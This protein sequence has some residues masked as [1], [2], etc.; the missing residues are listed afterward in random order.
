MV[1]FPAHILLDITTFDC[2]FLYAE[3]V[4]RTGSDIYRIEIGS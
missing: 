4:E 2:C 3:A 1:N